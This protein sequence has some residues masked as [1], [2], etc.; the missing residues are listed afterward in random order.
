[1]Q[2]G[3]GRG[4]R[5]CADC[6]VSLAACLLVSSAFLSTAAFA[7]ADEVSLTRSDQSALTNPE[8]PIVVGTRA[9]IGTDKAA[10]KAAKGVVGGV[11]GS[12]LG[13]SDD[14]RRASDR[15]DTVRDPTRKDDYVG[16]KAM[17]GGL[18]TAARAQ[19]TENGLLISVRI[20]DAPGKGTFH[21]IFLQACDGR[22]FYPRRYDIYKLWPERSVSVGWSRTTAVDGQVVDRDSG[23]VSEAWGEG[24][25]SGPI[26]PGQG[27]WQELGFERAHHGARQLG[28]YIDIDPAEFTPLG[29]LGLFVH[30]TL[31]SREPVTTAASI[32]LIG[33]DQDGEPAVTAPEIHPD[34]WWGHCGGSPADLVASAGTLVAEDGQEVGDVDFWD[35]FELAGV[36]A[37]V[38]KH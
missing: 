35:Q 10:E 23:S 24:V 5:R 19:W 21:T 34:G 9:A 28:A 3:A 20:D 38:L 17:D 1:M 16:I 33:P 18:E 6:A 29:E 14:G 36:E 30:T 27:I 22:R 25:G 31:P 37:K 32:W 11:I 7:Q 15:P 4:I 2:F 13:G 12:I 8:T 26:G